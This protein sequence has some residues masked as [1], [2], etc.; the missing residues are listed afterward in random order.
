MRGSV[1]DRLLASIDPV[2]GRRLLDQIE[3]G[4]GPGRGRRR[5]VGRFMPPGTTYQE[6]LS[7]QG[8]QDK[9]RGHERG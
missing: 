9:A 3:Q 2:R 8:L 6:W 7:R 4:N 5:V 1:H